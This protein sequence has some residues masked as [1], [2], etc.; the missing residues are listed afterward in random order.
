MS[1]T[2]VLSPELA[3][4]KLCHLLQAESPN[5]NH[6]LNFAFENRQAAKTRCEGS[7]PLSVAIKQRASYDVIVILCRQHPAAL[8]D[9]VN[10]MQETPLFR[11]LIKK[12]PYDVLEFLLD[13]SPGIERAVTVYG[14]T[15]LHYLCDRN[16]PEDKLSLLLRKY[17]QAAKLQDKL[18]RTPLH[19]MFENRVLLKDLEPLLKVN[20]DAISVQDIDGQTPVHQACKV[21]EYVEVFAAMIKISPSVGMTQDKHGKTP[22]HL[23]C[24][25]CV[26]SEVVPLLLKASPSAASVVDWRGQTPLHVA[27][28]SGMSSAIK[29]LLEADPSAVRALDYKGQSP[30]SLISS[31]LDM[32]A[33]MVLWDINRLFECELDLSI[34]TSIVNDFKYY[35]WQ[36]GVRLVVDAFPKVT[37]Y[38]DG[39]PTSVIP[40]AL[41]MMGQHCRMLS[42]WELVRNKPEIFK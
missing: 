36:F 21:C 27:C 29:C 11:A 37:R 13:E 10:D 32:E 41:S 4:A 22:L 6:I 39:T 42:V 38:L 2:T 18:G 19:C 34:V 15:P 17:P 33:T 31:D 7:Y 14:S 1:P 16:P 12:L 23:V 28:R 40:S 3:A 24:D 25:D 30:L 35:R 26:L 8:K 20:P 9:I 5:V